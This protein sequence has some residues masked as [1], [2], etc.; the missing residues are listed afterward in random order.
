VILTYCDRDGTLIKA[1][2]FVLTWFDGK[3]TQTSVLCP[4]CHSALV[5]WFGQGNP[6][7]EAVAIAATSLQSAAVLP[8][9]T[10][11]EPPA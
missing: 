9:V 11:M 8:G 1:E 5:Q 2:S 4:S 3:Q 10:P 7:P 6:S